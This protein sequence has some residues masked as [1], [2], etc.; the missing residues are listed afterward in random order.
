MQSISIFGTQV[1]QFGIQNKATHTGQASPSFVLDVPLRSSMADFVQ[2]DKIVLR[3]FRPFLS[4][5]SV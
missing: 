4:L 5:A 1:K 3:A 2:F